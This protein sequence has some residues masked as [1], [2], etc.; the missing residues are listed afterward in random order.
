MH[1]F[2]HIL[3]RS[4]FVQQFVMVLRFL[5]AHLL[6]IHVLLRNENHVFD[7]WLRKKHRAA[8]VIEVISRLFSLGKR[9]SERILYIEINTKQ[10]QILAS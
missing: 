2:V 9:V 1:K 10:K 3:A 6:I 4:Q 7:A 8:R 5:C